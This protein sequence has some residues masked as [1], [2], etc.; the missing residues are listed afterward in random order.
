MF[1]FVDSEHYFCIAPTAKAHL[2]FFTVFVVAGQ[3]L[4]W[5]VRRNGPRK[6]QSAAHDFITTFSV[7]GCT[8]VNNTSTASTGNRCIYS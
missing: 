4:R 2:F 8:I 6:Y 7:Y 3:V 5:F 1:D